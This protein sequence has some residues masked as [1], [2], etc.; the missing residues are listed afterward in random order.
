MDSSSLE[1]SSTAKT[2][3][4]RPANKT[5][6]KAGRTKVGATAAGGGE[7]SSQVSCLVSNKTALSGTYNS[8][9]SD[10]SRLSVA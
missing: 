6:S 5:K 7:T 9:H 3:K 10:Y 8:I 2:T 1:D 4:Q